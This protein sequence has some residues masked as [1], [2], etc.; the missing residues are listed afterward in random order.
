MQAPE[1]CAVD[2]SAAALQRCMQT[3]AKLSVAKLLYLP[4][5]LAAQLSVSKHF[6][7]SW[8]WRVR[9]GF[10][11]V[12]AFA[13]NPLRITRMLS[14]LKTSKHLSVGEGVLACLR[15]YV[16][17]LNPH[18]RAVN[19]QY[20]AANGQNSFKG[21]QTILAKHFPK[22]ATT[23]QRAQSLM[24]FIENKNI[25]KPPESLRGFITWVQELADALGTIKHVGGQYIRFQLARS[26]SHIYLPSSHTIT[27]AELLQIHP[28]QKQY[29][30]ALQRKY[31]TDAEVD[32][33]LAIEGI[34]AMDA[35]GLAAA[36]C[37]V[38]RINPNDLT[39][40]VIAR[41]KKRKEAHEAVFGIPPS[42]GVLHGYVRDIKM[43]MDEQKK[44]PSPK[45]PD[46]ITFDPTDP[47]G[48]AHV[49]FGRRRTWP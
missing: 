22:K 36:C 34:Q 10:S 32:P 42:C 38:A 19:G 30:P 20:N 16:Q 15:V 26:I 11:V 7:D 3:M 31:G 44:T 9:I 46:T 47:T 23:L 28:D 43:A 18:E 2:P 45:Y 37:Q 39:P 41:L 4:P 27:L 5:D 33:L 1:L 12:L 48:Y 14:T 35:W 21:H 29:L 17:E 40:A 25:Q 6:P 8:P 49:M 13:K 24:K